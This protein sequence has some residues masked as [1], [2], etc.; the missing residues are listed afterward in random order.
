MEV[1]TALCLG[2]FWGC[3]FTEVC[4]KVKKYYLQRKK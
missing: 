3:V 1:F 4:Y 2:F